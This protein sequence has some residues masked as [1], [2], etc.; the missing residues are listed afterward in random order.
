MVELQKKKKKKKQLRRDTK[1]RALPH[2][3]SSLKEGELE[4]SANLSAAAA[5]DD[6]DEQNVRYPFDPILVG[7]SANVRALKAERV[8]ELTRCLSPT[9][10]V[11]VVVV[12]VMVFGRL[13]GC[14]S[15]G[16]TSGGPCHKIL[17][18]PRDLFVCSSHLLLHHHLLLLLHSSSRENFPASHGETAQDSHPYACVCV[19][20][21]FFFFAYAWFQTR[22]RRRSSCHNSELGFLHKSNSFCP[23]VVV[24]QVRTIFAPC[25]YAFL[26]NCLIVLLAWSQGDWQSLGNPCEAKDLWKQATTRIPG[27]PI[28]PLI[29]SSKDPASSAHSARSHK[30]R[31]VQ[32]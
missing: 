13:W 21:L 10:V 27:N 9:L 1:P 2:A 19:Y 32:G 28:P 24:C 6:D 11:V 14:G 7:R 30:H 23:L 12:V 3:W 31:I 4:E 5:A 16:P 20:Y 25:R 15:G 17:I 18:I 26:D 29:S 22:S 8:R